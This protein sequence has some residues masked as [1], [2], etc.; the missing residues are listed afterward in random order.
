MTRPQA[1]FCCM[2]VYCQGWKKI[3]QTCNF[4]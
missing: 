2:S 4:N 3:Q 1:E